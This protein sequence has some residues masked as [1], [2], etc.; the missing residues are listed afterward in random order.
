VEKH[1]IQKNKIYEQQV[2]FIDNL[3]FCEPTAARTISFEEALKFEKIHINT[4]TQF[5]FQLHHVALMPISKRVNSILHDI[6]S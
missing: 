1:R 2:F 3:G 5:G 6:N 4:Y